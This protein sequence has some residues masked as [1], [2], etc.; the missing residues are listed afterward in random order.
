MSKS[1]KTQYR[2]IYTKIIKH[3]K[4]ILNG[5]R[6]NNQH[7]NGTL[8]TIDVSSKSCTCDKYLDKAICKYGVTM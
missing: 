7:Y 4:L 8:A 1:I 6:Y 2:K 5:G 3:N